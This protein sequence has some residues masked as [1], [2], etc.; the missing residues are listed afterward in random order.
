MDR[1]SEDEYEPIHEELLKQH[2]EKNRGDLED[3][4]PQ[5]IC[6]ECDEP[7]VDILILRES[8]K[9]QVF[10][11]NCPFCGGESWELDIEGDTMIK[12]IDNNV[13][14]SN[15]SSEPLNGGFRKRATK[16]SNRIELCNS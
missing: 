15:M 14:I 4:M 9:E 8:Q 13:Q 10:S 3:V 1:L 16:F 11:C 7:L 2:I 12:V 6:S 5:L